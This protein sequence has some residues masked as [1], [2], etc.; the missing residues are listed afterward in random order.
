MLKKIAF[1]HPSFPGGGAE[2]ITLDIIKYMKEHAGDRYEPYVITQRINRQFMSDRI[3]SL[4]QILELPDLG[5]EQQAIA[6][7]LRGL[8]RQYR[9][10][11]LVEVGGGHLPD[12]RK[13]AD[14]YGCRLVFAHH[15]EPLWEKHLILMTEEERCSH[16]ILDRIVWKLFRRFKYTV[17]GKAKRKAAAICLNHYM[18]SDAYTVLCDEYRDI[19]IRSMHLD[20]DKNRVIV[21][22]NPEYPARDLNLDKSRTILFV[23]RLSYF[24]KRVD[25]LL[26]IWKK[27]QDRLP[28][29]R[30]QIVGDGPER[31]AL[32]EM[33]RNMGLK[34]VSFEG[35]H[36]DVSGYYRNASIS[37]LTSTSEGWPLCLTEAQANGVIPIAFGCTGGVREILSPDGANGFIV[38]PFRIRKFADTLVRV[39]NMPET[40]KM[41]IRHNA[42]RKAAEYSIDTICSRWISLFDSLITGNRQTL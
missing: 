24:D 3:R 13:T 8:F 6:E 33:A 28:D 5:S 10:S 42:V 14:S 18:D 7:S 17:L 34:R 22:N 19:F 36:P 25:R 31:Q 21:M 27:A 20:P 4:V 40:E 38:K 39:A 1:Y 2:R 9:F 12:I 32:M 26:R 29:Y 30:L 11:I 37:C 16:R 35:Y 15:S 23:G 41:E